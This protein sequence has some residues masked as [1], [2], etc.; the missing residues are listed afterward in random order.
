M[1]TLIGIWGPKAAGFGLACCE[2]PPDEV[3]ILL[4]VGLARR[5]DPQ[6]HPKTATIEVDRP[7]LPP[8]RTLNSGEV[9]FS[10]N[11]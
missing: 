6:T 1:C 7:K 3:S 5:Q 8:Q 9:L 2:I 11:L 10:N 4:G